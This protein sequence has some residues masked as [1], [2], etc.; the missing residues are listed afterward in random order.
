MEGSDR[1]LEAVVDLQGLRAEL[2]DADVC[3]AVVFGSV[4]SGTLSPTSD[5]DLC[6]RFA[7]TCSRRERFRQRNRLDA[8]IQS[9]ADRF[10]DVS[11]LEALPDTIALNAL[12]DGVLVYGDGATKA[13]DE[14]RLAQRVA[15]SSDRRE[16]R[17]REFVDRLAEGDV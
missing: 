1:A 15:E 6:I 13:A 4:A 12:R 5:L 14:R 11:D 17:R 3:Y 2:D 10:V 9:T 8:A 7:E 16:R